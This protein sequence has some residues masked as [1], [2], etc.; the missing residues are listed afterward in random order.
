MQRARLGL[1]IDHFFVFLEWLIIVLAAG[2]VLR[3][4]FGYGS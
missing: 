3:H 1:I 4:F 2:L